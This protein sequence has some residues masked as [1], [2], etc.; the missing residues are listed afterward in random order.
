MIS[1]FDSRLVDKMSGAVIKVRLVN[2]NFFF[3]WLGIQ[4]E[5][6]KERKKERSVEDRKGPLSIR[7]IFVV[8]EIYNPLLKS[9]R[10]LWCNGS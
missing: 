5:R 3:H 9:W 7:F 2:E 6:K 4:K 8:S 1:I 10:R